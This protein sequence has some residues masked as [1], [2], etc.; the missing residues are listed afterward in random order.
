MSHLAPADG[1]EQPSP[2]LSY[3][4][5]VLRN[6]RIKLVASLARLRH[7]LLQLLQLIPYASHLNAADTPARQAWQ[8]RHF[9]CTCPAQQQLLLNKTRS[10]TNQQL[11]TF[12]RSRSLSIRL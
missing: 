6:G 12:H 7:D 4:L 5:V 8:Q 9:G 11:H 2:A 10:Q 1:H 3:G